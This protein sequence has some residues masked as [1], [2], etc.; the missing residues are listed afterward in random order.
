[1][2]VGGV[3]VIVVQVRVVVVALR[4]GRKEGG[5]LAI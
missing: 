4:G 3:L 2:I 1:M 5:E